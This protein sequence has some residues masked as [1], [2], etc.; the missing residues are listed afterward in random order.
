MLSAA[1]CG[2]VFTSPSINSILQAILSCNSEKTPGC[3]LL[4]KQYTGDI[5]NFKMAAEIAKKKGVKNIKVFTIGDDCSIIN[6]K[7]G[8]RGLAGTVYFH[9]IA[10]QLA[11]EGKSLDEIYDYLNKVG[12]WVSTIGVSLGNCIVP[13]SKKASFEL[14]EDEVEFGLGIHVKNHK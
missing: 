4:V 3:L 14:K 7:V 6:N 8:R 5:I 12:K 2:E 13:G 1:V 10:G 9:K 11:E